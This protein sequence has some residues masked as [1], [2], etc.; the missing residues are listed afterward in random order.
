VPRINQFKKK[1][2]SFIRH[3]IFRQ[4]YYPITRRY[5]SKKD[6][7]RKEAKKTT[8]RAG[9]AKELHP[10]RIQFSKQ[11][12]LNAVPSHFD[13]TPSTASSTFDFLQI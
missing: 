9:R 6:G 3:L 5:K 4:G 2:R 11:P 12:C 1:Q 7:A 13:G 10:S 8:D